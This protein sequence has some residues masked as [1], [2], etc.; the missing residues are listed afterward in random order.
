MVL[1]PVTGPTPWSIESE[2]APV[3]LHARVAGVPAATVAG[4]AVNDEITGALGGGVVGSPLLEVPPQA[5]MN[6]LTA[7]A[8]RSGNVRADRSILITGRSLAGWRILGDSSKGTDAR[9]L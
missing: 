2:V 1:A 9:A 7:I 5:M 3:T 8:A 6:M 4:V